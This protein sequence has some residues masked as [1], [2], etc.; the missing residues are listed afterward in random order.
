MVEPPDLALEDLKAMVRDHYGEKLHELHFLPLG[1]DP[2]SALYRG[3]TGEGRAVCLKLRRGA[4]A[5]PS[6]TLPARLAR[7]GLSTIVS[8]I[9]T[10]SGAFRVPG[11]PWTLALYPFVKGRPGW[12]VP[13]ER[14]HWTALGQTLRV[15]HDLPTGPLSQLPREQFG[16][17]FRERV[18]R[19]L[20][21]HQGG[22]DSAAVKLQRFLGK[23]REG[24]ARMLRQTGDLADELKREPPP[25]VPCHGDIHAG[26]LLIGESLKVVDWDTL[27]LAPR[28]KD[29]MFIGGGVGGC[30]NRPG[31]EAWFYDA[32]GAV[33]INAR[34]LVY[35]RYERIIED[36]AE[37]ATLIGEGDQ[38]NPDRDIM[39]D[40]L[41]S[42]FEPGNVVAMAE[43]AEARLF[44]AG[45][46]SPDFTIDPKGGAE[47]R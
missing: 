30:W 12:E 39:A 46:K 20:G 47:R 13:L 26:N 29:L 15:L 32:Y 23:R 28:E 3:V 31:E 25:F 8:P 40:L 10:V 22:N 41:D 44:R 17:R 37:I 35:Y 11:S 42:Q 19:L 9:A 14:G 45:A 24:I 33:P 34:A 7:E 27:L 38:G 21:D 4:F 36:I 18:E 5:E 6:V 2:D 16:S 1:A 43:A